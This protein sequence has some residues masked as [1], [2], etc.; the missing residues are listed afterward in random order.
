VVELANRGEEKN[1]SPLI[2]K[3]FLVGL[4]LIHPI[5]LIS[6]IN[7]TEKLI[8]KTN[9]IEFYH[10]S[11]DIDI[12]KK[13]ISGKCEM[14]FKMN[15]SSDTLVLGL[16]SNYRIIKVINGDQSL[17]YCRKHNDILIRLN[18]SYDK[19]LI[20]N[21]T[22]YYEGIPKISNN[23]PWDAGFVWSKDSTGKPFVGVV[24]E[25]GGAGIWW[26]AIKDISKKTDSLLFSVTIPKGLY[27]VSN[28]ELR[29]VDTTNNKICYNWFNPYP[30]INYNLTVYIGKYHCFYRTLKSNNICNSLSYYSLNNNL[31]NAEMY[32]NQIDTILKVFEYYYGRYPFF[33]IGYKLVDAPYAGME[34]QTAIAIGNSEKS[35]FNHLGFKTNISYI[36][37]HETAH[38]WWGN[39]ISIK[40]MSDLWINESFATYSES[41]FLE[42]LFG[43]EKAISYINQDLEYLITNKFPLCDTTQEINYTLDI[44]MKGS[45]VWNTFRHLLDNDSLWFDFLHS[46]NKDYKF[47]SVSTQGLLNYINDYFKNDFTYFFDQYIYSVKIPKLEVKID[48]G[49]SNKI[50]IRWY[51][52]NPNF[53]MPVYYNNKSEKIYINA[54]TDWKTFTINNF[55]IEDF[56]QLQNSYLIRIKT[57]SGVDL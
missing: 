19:S 12:D 54:T 4:M 9:H 28:G 32:F 55:S 50:K 10:L 13:F 52:C 25:L 23:A 11:I 5:S 42:Y 37:V 57:L 38:E 33:E 8:D 49:S 17:S 16:D 31:S 7:G 47:K 36:L 56:K 46:I 24:C 15:N 2:M 1:S 6:Q 14:N 40:A 41:L 3:I 35:I 21:I 51:D 20:Q 45:A 22:V 53:K 44:Y 27:A 43:K 30:I 18:G 39:S 34:H 26:P 48:S 29:N